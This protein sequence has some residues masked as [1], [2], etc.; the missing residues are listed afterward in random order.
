MAPTPRASWRARC[1]AGV[2]LLISALGCAQDTPR[3]GAE[4]ATVYLLWRE[5]CPHCERAIAWLQGREAGDPALRVSYMEVSRVRAHQALLADLVSHFAL[6]RV[7]VPMVIVGEH[8]FVGFLDEASTGRDI[9]AAIRACQAIGCRDVVAARIAALQ[10]EGNDAAAGTP[11]RAPRD[12]PSIPARIRVPLLGEIDTRELSLGVLTVILAAAD[13]FNPCAMWTLVFLLGLIGGMADRVR[14]WVLGTTFVVASAVVYF[15]FMAAW[16]NALL[17]LGMITWLRMALGV[18][19]LGGGTYYLL[20]GFS[21]ADP[22]CSVT[23]PAGRRKVFDALRDL[24]SEK[25]FALA[26]AGIVSIAFAVNAVEL[27]CSA[28]IPVVYT[29]ILALTPLARWQYYAYLALYVLIFML[30]DIVVLVVTLGAITLAGVGAGFT[31]WSNRLGGAILLLLGVLLLF[32]PDLL[33]LG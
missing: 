2:L 27:I 24:A 9:D 4:S 19:A 21:R 18:L 22:T 30:D 17:L 3:A 1:L 13:G 8:A 23:A 16:L 32:R 31:R 11:R 5:G 29:Q 26:L 12:A 33:V 14:M 28:G 25:R 15:M 20:Q 6:D 7:A 10:S